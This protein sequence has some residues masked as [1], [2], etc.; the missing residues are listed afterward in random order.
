MKHAVASFEV[1]D[2]AIT[3]IAG[4]PETA[5][6]LLGRRL[7][8]LELINCTP[9]TFARLRVSAERRAQNNIGPG[10]TLSDIYA[11]LDFPLQLTDRQKAS[12]MRQEQL[13]QSDLIR[14]VPFTLTRIRHLRQR[15]HKIVF[16]SDVH[17]PTEFT[18][19]LLM[20]CKLWEPGDRCYL[21]SEHGKS[22]ASSD[23]FRQ[24]LQVEEI[25]PKEVT[26]LGNDIGA[27][28]KAPRRVGIDAE[29]FEQGNLN[30]YEQILDSHAWATEGLSSVMAGASRLARLTIPASSDHQVSVRDV[31]AGVVAPLLV[32]YLLW[33]L[34]RAKELELNCLY[35]LSRDGQILLQMARQLASALNLEIE[36]RYLYASRMSW[37]QA[38]METLDEHWIWSPLSRSCSLERLFSRLAI[39]PHE[40][41]FS[42]AKFGFSEADWTRS[43]DR[44]EME[45]LK[46]LL[47]EEP[48]ESLAFSKA[49]QKRSVLELYF[50]QEG[51]LEGT[52]NGIVDL[53]W[54]GS[55]YEAS[56]RLRKGLNMEPL[57]GLY[58][59][60]NRSPAIDRGSDSLEAYF[61]DER[62]NQG[63]LNNDVKDALEV[64]CSA[65]HGTVIGF[66]H[67]AGSQVSPV[68]KSNVNQ[69]VIDWGL[70]I[71]RDTAECFVGNLILKP[72]FVN[73]FADVRQATAQAFE[74]FWSAPTPTEARVWGS[75]PWEYHLP[76]EG[77]EPPTWARRYGWRH[78]LELYKQRRFPRSHRHEW[79]HGSLMQS[80]LFVRNIL[81]L[82]IILRSRFRK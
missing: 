40:I 21:S 76:S 11:E 2:T 61:F 22:K 7:A 29:L 15:G 41:A 72:E 31:T 55:M 25:S 35:F 39:A 52:R 37:N 23:L 56:S 36:L 78:V 18:E 33:V 28:L 17:L 44:T 69:R 6:L 53:G 45:L 14:P 19:Q 50:K 60:K 62:A 26:H 51:L 20:A 80:P 47:S 59:G 49:R 43:L 3:R 42:L 32:G 48:V 27:D 63:I 64:F 1:F 24:L 30:R 73:P 71:L 58:F 77:D 16:V 5:F 79:V 54:A 75:L 81:R 70:P 9:E 82:A 10:M 34:R 12:L 74:A 13:L 4:S 67:A 8:Y 66:E 46:S 38:T 65:D 68:L 57:V